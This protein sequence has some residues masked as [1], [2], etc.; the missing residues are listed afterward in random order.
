MH[1]TNPVAP[2]AGTLVGERSYS[3]GATTASWS[4]W[5]RATTSWPRATRAP[6]TTVNGHYAVVTD[7]DAG[8]C[9]TW[10]EL[11]GRVRQVCS[12][13]AGDTAPLATPTLLTVAR[14]LR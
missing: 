10:T 4:A 3:H 13:G 2:T 1:S 6:N 12:S 5:G 14:S 11:S 8:R 7:S 9:V